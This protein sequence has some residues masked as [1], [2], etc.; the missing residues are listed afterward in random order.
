L[1]RTLPA[2]GG[3]GKAGQQAVAKREA[4]EKKILETAREM[5]M[6]AKKAAEVAEAKR[7]GGG[8]VDTQLWTEKYAPKAM[9]DII[10]NKGLVEK[11]GRW[12]HDWYQLSY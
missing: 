12:L 7:V 10:G 3:G 11:L 2:N 1:I 5:E 9:K 6:Q 4:E 8:A